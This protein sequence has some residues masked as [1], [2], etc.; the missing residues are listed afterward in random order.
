MA[1]RRWRRWTAWLLA[2]LAGLACLFA[3][4][5]LSIDRLNY[6]FNIA[7]PPA[8]NML[9]YS[10]E[11]HR[12]PREELS[13]RLYGPQAQL[14]AA[15]DL[16]LNNMGYFSRRD[17]DYQRG[18]NE[19]RIVTI[20][21]EQT[22]SSVANL[23]W[24][25]SLEDELNRRDP[26]TRYKVFNIA[27]PD[28]G[29]EHYVRYWQEE[30]R[31]FDPDLVIVHFVEGDFYRKIEGTPLKYKGQPIELRDIEYR[32][33]P[34]ADDAAYTKT[35]QIVGSQVTS[36]RDPAAIPSR[37]YGFFSTRAF[38]SDPKKVAALQ[39]QVVKD[40]IAGAEP[41]WA[42]QR[43]L[44]NRPIAIKVEDRNFDRLP[45]AP[46]D[47]DKL[48]EFGVANFGWLARNVPNVLITH[49]FNYAERTDPF[50]LTAAMTSKDP[51]IKVIDLRPRVAPDT[52]DAELRSW[53]VV[54]AM[55]EKWTDKGHT[56]LGK[57]MADL[58]MERKREMR[59]T[60]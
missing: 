24:P 60:N 29:P 8:V 35:A 56:V 28:A 7:H 50:A 23:S 44:Q 38:M 32:F 15:A 33:G 26:S 16:R 53:Y 20:G 12:K 17:Y 21:G 31:K 9:F 52:S 37:P 4:V 22:A 47:R 13:F 46:V 45:S 54:P 5:E 1:N 3:I 58:V 27:W 48:V 11:I 36:Y 42:Y 6:N 39:A 18:P 51:Q 57:M 55:T 2:P 49:N 34:G 40:M 25:D 14:I 59:K 10:G 30:G 19:F 41:G 43:W